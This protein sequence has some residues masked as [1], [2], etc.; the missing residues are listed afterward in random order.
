MSIYERV[1]LPV[2]IRKDGSIFRDVFI[3][4]MSG[5]DEEILS[6]P[7]FK[8]SPVRAL[9]TLLQRCVQEIPG[10]MEP[11]KD[12]FTLAPLEV[13]RSMYQ[14]D[15]DHLVAAVRRISLGDEV[16]TDWQCRY[17]KVD[18]EDRALL[19]E[20]P[21]VEWPDDRATTFPFEI[22]KGA[23]VGD[24]LYKKGTLKLLSGVDAEQVA[25]SVARN[26][27]GAGT[28]FLAALIVSW[29]DGTRPTIDSLRK[30]RSSDRG[31]LAELV[32]DQ[33]PGLRMMHDIVCASCGRLNESVEVDA[34]GFF[35][36]TSRK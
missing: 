5:V 12:P 29:E 13:L 15:R 21:V 8:A 11:K 27:E 22:E 33:M 26:P 34:S 16:I 19:S 17:C 36:S 25:A 32:R 28:A 9:T 6:S 1:R 7:K 2:G 24:K 3:D 18:N 31:K 4:E 30:M 35:A 10:L 20:L 14:I 23:Q